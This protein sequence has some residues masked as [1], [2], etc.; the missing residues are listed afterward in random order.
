MNNNSGWISVE[1]HLP[2]DHPDIKIGN[3]DGRFQMITVLVYAGRCVS[4]R[5]RLRIDRVGNDYLD[6]QATDG[7]VWSYG[8]EPEFW[9]PLPHTPERRFDA[10]FVKYGAG[11]CLT[12]D[13]INGLLDCLKY[14]EVLP[15]RLHND[16]TG[17]TIVGFVTKKA[18]ASLDFDYEETGFNAALSALMNLA[19][20]F[21]P[22][23][24]CDLNVFIAPFDGTQKS[25][26]ISAIL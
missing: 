15:Y 13:T 22:K 2:E 11:E 1:D 12:K 18:A 14:E 24:V 8:D 17:C 20:E 16:K 3:F 9:M 6:E 5:N 21:G 25:K 26:S 23:V 4:M 19:T 10:A 7:W